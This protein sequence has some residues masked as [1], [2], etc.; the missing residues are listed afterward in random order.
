M[1]CTLPLLLAVAGAIQN[2]GPPPAVRLT[3]LANE[4]VML[5]SPRGR[6]L[7][8]ALFGD[9]LPEYAVLPHPLRDSLE[10]AAGDYG[11][12]ALV[13]STHAHRDHY[14][15][16]AVGRYLA[17]NPDA[18]VIGPPGVPP[19]D[20]VRAADLGWVR[21]RPIPVPHGPTLRPVKHTWYL[22]DLGGTTALH[23]GDTSADPKG[24]SHLELPAR[25]VDIALVPYWY[26]LE[27]ASF[28]RLLDVIHARTVVL[29]HVSRGAG[30]GEW[31]ARFRELQARYPQ[32]RAPWQPGEVVD[33]AP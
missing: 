16:A 31:P 1:G 5:S 4:G 14:D 3:Y 22:I 2:P 13:L 26:A 7:I 10:R 20:E 6:V 23:L 29:L 19:H 28:Q 11:G 32:V 18:V 15:S 33:P 9:G 17:S 30:R 25:G 12:P 21:V 8:D 27:D 24:W